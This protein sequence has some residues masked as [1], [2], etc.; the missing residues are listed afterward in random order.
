MNAG[1]S[2][3]TNDL[4]VAPSMPS[5]EHVFLTARQVIARYGWG[6]TK[7]YRMLK[8]DDF[9]RAIG[10][11]RYRLDTLMEWERR[12][13]AEAPVRELPQLPGSKRRQARG[14]TVSIGRGF[15]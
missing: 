8:S 15:G 4:S 11:D 6:R 9:P 5:P 13:Q 2:Q 1:T 14:S 10:G 12:Q 7:G 3:E